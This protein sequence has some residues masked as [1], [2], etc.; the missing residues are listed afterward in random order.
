[1]YVLSFIDRTNIAMATP[2][3]RPEFGISA[4]SIGLATG[5]FCWGYIILQIPSG[6]LAAAWKVRPS[7]GSAAP[8]GRRSPPAP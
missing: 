3:L 6:R 2:A 8:A 1:M 7:G 5:M 4:S